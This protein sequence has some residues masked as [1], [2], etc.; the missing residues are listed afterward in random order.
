MS[1]PNPYQP[2]K[3]PEPLRRSQV[4]KR[5]LGVAAIL[6]LT[7]PA[8][9]IATAGSCAAATIVPGQLAAILAIAGPFG[10]L[11]G[12]MIWATALDRPGRGD[13][14]RGSSRAGIFL[15]TPV[16]VA[17]A[18][19]IGFGLGGLAVYW[20]SVNE[21]GLSERGMWIGLITFFSLPTAAL[22]AML[23]IAW[24]AGRS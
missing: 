8:M 24:R 10:A 7:P 17:V 1:N 16:V 12:L 13:P 14:N 18:A 20:T 22:L 11:T 15:A 4:V 19:G 21:G 3:M 5:G 2:P 6:L 9:A 23:T